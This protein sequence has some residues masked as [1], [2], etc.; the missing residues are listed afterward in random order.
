MFKSLTS[1]NKKNNV[2]IHEF[3]PEDKLSQNLT[4]IA[5]SYARIFSTDD[6]HK[7]LAHLQ[8]TTL[9]RT[10][11]PE[12]PESQIRHLDGQRFVVGKILRMISHGKKP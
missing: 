3:L 10:C 5:K 7:V 12:A 9:Y 1:K 11:P 6:G 8:S 4:D 2:T